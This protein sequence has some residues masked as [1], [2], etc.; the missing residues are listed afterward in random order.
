[1]E[2]ESKYRVSFS[3]GMAH[4]LGECSEKEATEIARLRSLEY[5]DLELKLVK[6]GSGEEI[7][8]KLKAGLKL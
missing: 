6:I 2:A 8:W 7:S 1:M 5:N 4:N 3:N